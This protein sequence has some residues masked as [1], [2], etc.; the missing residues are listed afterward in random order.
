MTEDALDQTTTD[1]DNSGDGAQEG[2]GAPSQDDLTADD[3]ESG[4][5]KKI[6]KLTRKRRDAERA[7]QQAR[8]EALYYRGLAEGKGT[9]EGLD[10]VA[11][12]TLGTKDLDRLDFESDAD[13]HKALAQQIKS[14]IEADF[15]AKENAKKQAA[16]KSKVL[17]HYESGR[18]KFSDFDNVALD[19]GLQV[20]ESMFEAAADS[21]KMADILY[22]L[23]KNPDETANIATMS[24]VAQAKAIGRIEAGLDSSTKKTTSAPSPPTTV[25]TGGGNPPARTEQEMLDAGARADL[26]KKWEAERLTRLGV[27]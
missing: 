3:T 16:M 23:G 7:A 25:G 10:R 9:D 19:P 13:Y 14:E 2:D 21:D 5:K 17:K 18:K 12:A 4:V 27:K 11:D 15:A 20:T 24:P 1:V 6:D 22:H 8:E 26:H